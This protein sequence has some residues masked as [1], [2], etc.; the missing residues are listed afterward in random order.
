M[1]L[2]IVDDDE[3][4][5]KK[6]VESIE[7]EDFGIDTV[8]EANN[9]RKAK[10]I[11]KK[12]PIHILLS[13]IE[14]PQG[15]GLELLEWIRSKDIPVECIILSSY[16]YFAYAQKAIQLHTQEYL[17]K[18][19]KNSELVEAI[20][21]VAIKIRNTQDHEQ[22][23]LQN[24]KVEFWKKC[25]SEGAGASND[26]ELM[27]LYGN[28]GFMVAVISV[29]QDGNLEEAREPLRTGLLVENGLT[30]YFVGQDSSLEA[31][32]RQ[33]DE[34]WLLVLRISDMSMNHKEKFLKLRNYLKKELRLDTFLYVG[35]R[36][37]M[38]SLTASMECIRTM[39][40]EGIMP[41]EGLLCEEDWVL[42]E[43]L[44][45]TLPWKSWEWDILHEETF[46]GIE[47]ELMDTVRRLVQNGEARKETFLQ[48][49]R[50]LFL[51]VHLFLNQM[52]VESKH[53][54]ENQEFDLYYERSIRSITGMTDY[55]T[56]IFDKLSGFLN[57]NKANI[58]PV[59]Q[60]KDYIQI[61]LKED[62]SRSLLAKQVFLSEDYISK[63]FIKEVGMSLPAYITEARMKRAREYLRNSNATVS[64]VAVSVGYSNF[65]YFSKSFKD[66]Y[67][68]TPNEC[69]MNLSSS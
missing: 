24:K 18:P 43:K 33:S 8:L 49:R 38:E 35:K 57:I 17:L 63:I 25:I 5:I 11:L 58:S 34:E 55:I 29:Q 9:I 1:N 4:L 27:K 50:D 65:S 22:A 19:V 23:W 69:R 16:A 15:S 51:M 32:V 48:F 56:Y 46:G 68:Y 30:E 7:W 31:V 21:R 6:I 3:L 41:E 20:G 36:C 37:T 45:D 13:D 28:G 67:G 40:R 59:N 53:I 52:G 10:D 54:F 47:K 61:H 44:C 42:Q 60:I 26:P 14:M 39:L 64:E 66:Y 2:L 62:L 12:L